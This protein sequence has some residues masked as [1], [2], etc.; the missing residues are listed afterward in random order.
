MN[1]SIADIG[2]YRRRDYMEN[3]KFR[4]WYKGIYTLNQIISIRDAEVIGNKY[5][6]P[7]LLE[8]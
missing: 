6:Y 5:E 3:L 7:H 4:A 2:I 1:Y 8:E